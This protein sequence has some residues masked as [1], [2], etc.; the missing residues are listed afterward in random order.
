MDICE[1][2]S[3]KHSV[4]G[5]RSNGIFLFRCV[6]YTAA[7][8]AE[9][10]F[11]MPSADD[12]FEQVAVYDSERG[13]VPP[14]NISDLE[15]AMGKIDAVQRED[16]LTLEIA[17]PD[18]NSSLPVAVW[19]HGGANCFGAGSLPWYDPGPLAKAVNCVIINVNFRLGAFGFFHHPKVCTGNLSI[20]DQ[21]AA[22]RWI[23]RHAHQFGGDASRVTVFGQSAGANAIL[24]ILGRPDSA[25]LFSQV[26]LQS[27]SIGRGNHSS[28][29]AAVIAECLM[30]SLGIDPDDRPDAIR[31]HLR[32]CSVKSILQAMSEIEPLCIPRFGNMLFKPVDD[33]RLT[34]FDII[35]SAAKEAVYRGVRIMIGTTRDEMSA[36][37]RDTDEL[38]RSKLKNIQADR[39]DRPA[40][41]FA[42]KVAGLGGDIRL[43]RFDWE[44]PE[45]GFHACHCIELPFVFGTWRK[46]AAPMIAGVAASEAQRLTRTMQQDWGCF[47]NFRDFDPAVWPR[48]NTVKPSR[49]IFDN[50]ANPIEYF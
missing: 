18:I 45:S 6:R 35:E 46:W 27:P 4:C 21:M 19:F 39:F 7:Q 14:Q 50:A 3:G 28:S 2:R 43:Y 32:S 15:A 12:I 26:L 8:T 11:C 22:L 47:F 29:D 42:K 24:H 38:S 33:N 36:F 20:E 37:C 41:A 23:Q 25:G 16:C 5:C 31:A 48:F 30:K 13:M 1:I 10:R 9:R 17:T 49:R 34:A 44:A 40:V